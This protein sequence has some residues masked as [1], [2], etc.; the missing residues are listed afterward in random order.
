LS[1]LRSTIKHT[2]ESDGSAFDIA[3]ASGG[4]RAVGW[5]RSQPLRRG[6]GEIVARTRL[7]DRTDLARHRKLR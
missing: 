1:I 3:A 4:G 6:S 5:S 7:R 2:I